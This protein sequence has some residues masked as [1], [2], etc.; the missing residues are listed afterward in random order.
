VAKNEVFDA[1]EK[2][3]VRHEEGSEGAREGESKKAKEVEE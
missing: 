3:V 1:V 2:R